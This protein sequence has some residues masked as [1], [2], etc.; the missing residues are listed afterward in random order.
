MK[1]DILHTWNGAMNGDHST[2]IATTRSS[3]FTLKDSQQDVS[4]LSSEIIPGT[5]HQTGDGF[6]GVDS[7]KAGWQ[8]NSLRSW[9]TGH[10]SMISSA[11]GSAFKEENRV[12][13]SWDMSSS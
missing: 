12:D 13:I 11:H 7:T 2:K 10:R 3:D 6:L 8:E 9:K 4:S 1:L 5:W